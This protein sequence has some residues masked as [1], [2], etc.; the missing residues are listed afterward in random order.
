MLGKYID[1]H[2]IKGECKIIHVGDRQIINPRPIDFINAG[3]KEVI[4]DDQ[5]EFD[6]NKEDLIAYYDEDKEHIFEHWKVEP[7]EKESF[8]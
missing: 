7:Q 3:Y 6:E 4:S 8:L 2:H 1:E 5:P